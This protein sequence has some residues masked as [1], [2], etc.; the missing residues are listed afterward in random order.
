VEKAWLAGVQASREIFEVEAPGDVDI[1][2]ASP[3]GHPRDINLYQSQK[4]MAAAELVIK[5]G[6]TIILPAACP[7]GVG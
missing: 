6:G 1:V 7:D 2:I 5:E 3:G 4:S